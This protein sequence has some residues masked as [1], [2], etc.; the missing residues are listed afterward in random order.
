MGYTHSVPIAERVSY[1]Y[2]DRQ[3]DLYIESVR[4]RFSFV[5][6]RKQGP[7]RLRFFNESVIFEI[8]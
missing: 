1:M 4:R 5:T 6:S 2:T 8:G 7:L 3:T